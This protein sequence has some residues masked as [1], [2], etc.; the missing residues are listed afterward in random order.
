MTAL[1]VAV[2]AE[3]EADG[4]V[5]YEIVAHVRQVAVQPVAVPSIRT[6]GWPAVRRQLPAVV[7]TVYYQSDADALVV[8]ADTDATTPHDPATHTPGAPHP[9]CRWCML[10]TELARAMSLLAPRPGRRPLGTALGAPV[11]ALEGWLL[12]GRAAH[13]SEAAWRPRGVLAASASESYK[14]RL[15]EEAYGPGPPFQA[16][17]RTAATLIRQVLATPGALRTAYPG[18]YGPL[19]DAIRSW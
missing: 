19:E 4:A 12:A 16:T 2:L 7:R 10:G 1:R 8:L 3:S 11:P 6:R 5:V 13:A 18:G 9:D 15:K 14:R 17:P